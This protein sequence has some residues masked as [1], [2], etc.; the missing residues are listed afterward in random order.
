M[1]KNKNNEV[2]KGVCT[3]I[4]KGIKAFLITVIQIFSVVGLG[5]IL[6]AGITKIM[7][8]GIEVLGPVRM[9]HLMAVLLISF[10]ILAFGV[11]FFVTFLENYHNQ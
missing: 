4:V 7:E 6:I 5:L 11:F 9:D 3:A 10:C 8:T 2:L 1:A